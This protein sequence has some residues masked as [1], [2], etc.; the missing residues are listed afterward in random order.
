MHDHEGNFDTAIDGINTPETQTADND[1]AVG[2]LIERVAHSPYASSTLIFVIE[3]DAQAGPDHVN[4]HRTIAFVAGAYVKQGVVIHDRF[5]TV[6]MVRTIEDVLGIDHLNLNDAYQR[7]MTSIF[8]LNQANW[9][10]TAVMPAPIAKD[11]VPAEGQAAMEFHGAQSAAYWVRQTRGYDWSVEDR[12]P[13]V[14]FNQ[15]IWKGLTG[16]LP[17]P[18]TRSGVDLSDNRAAVLKDRSVHFLYD[19]ND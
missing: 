15:A 8:D 6:N 17:Y 4:A 2:K 11:V 19:G 13:A 12:V 1:Y 5:T 9:T 16:G 10:Y 3:D 18:A 14:P 7:P